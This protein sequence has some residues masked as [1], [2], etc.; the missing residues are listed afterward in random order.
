MIKPN[1]HREKNK[2]HI[3]V[4]GCPNVIEACTEHPNILENG[5]ATFNWSHR[6]E[7]LCIVVI[8]HIIANNNNNR[9]R[10]KMKFIFALLLL[11]R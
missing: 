9:K 6:F 1:V 11:L 4:E 3:E 2:S 8:S 7:K 10:I 5:D